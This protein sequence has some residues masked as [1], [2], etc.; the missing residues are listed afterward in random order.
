MILCIGGVLTKEEL[1][2]VNTRLG[3]TRFTSGARTAGWHARQVKKNEQAAYPRSPGMTAAAGI[4][5]VA[6][7]RNDL[8][9]LAVRPQRQTPV[10]FNRHQPGM[11]YGAHVDDAL[12]RDA[13]G[14]TLRTDI[15]VT[16][17]LSDPDTY[18]GGALI[19][20]DTAGERVYRLA[21]GDAIAYPATTLHRVEPVS[22]GARLAAVLWVQSQVPDAA[23]REILFDLDTA[24]RAMFQAGGKTREFDLVTKSHANLLRR[25]SQV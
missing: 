22:R 9:K 8:F 17:F 4:V 3:K 18:D 10:L 25:W 1:R 12:M 14:A 23:Q 16:V 11:E 13:D 21:A 2:Q 19:I 15:A 20:E 6:L 7:N 5:T 24:R